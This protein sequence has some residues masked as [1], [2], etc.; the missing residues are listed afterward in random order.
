MKQEELTNL[1][2]EELQKKEK[3]LKTLTGVF[4]GMQV[5]MTILGVF[6]LLQK[7]SFVFASLPVAFLP[8]LLANLANLKKITAEIAKRQ[9]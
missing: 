4:L 3:S 6:I 8:L 5:V 1:S 7:G 9:G 2:L